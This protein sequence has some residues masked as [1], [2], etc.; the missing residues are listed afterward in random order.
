METLVFK[1]A[2]FVVQN[3]IK[4]R[5]KTCP[6]DCRNIINQLK[7]TNCDINKILFNGCKDGDLYWVEFAVRNGADVNYINTFHCLSCL[8][9][10]L[11]NSR[12]IGKY[13]VIQILEF[14]ESKGVVF[15]ENCV[16]NARYSLVF[17][18]RLIKFLAN[19]VNLHQIDLLSEAVM[20]NQLET[21]KVL[22]TLGYTLGQGSLREAIDKDYVEMVEYILS[23]GVKPTS[24]H[25]HNAVFYDYRDI[26]KLLV[27]N[28]PSIITVELIL[29][30]LNKER[31]AI[32]KVLVQH[33]NLVQTD[34]RIVQ[35]L[36]YC[37]R[38]KFLKFVVENFNFNFNLDLKNATNKVIQLLNK[39]E[40]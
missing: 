18:P 37:N 29:M 33:S 5:S 19:K 12:H 32:A 14:L 21:I 6:Q 22:I 17:Q 34:N 30:A 25:L 16:M 10:V 15:P 4:H 2:R 40:K 23:R 8:G 38:V 31:Y 11:N 13:R 27:E 7:Q 24:I 36:V 35:N 28:D 3:K 39:I 1:C 9:A 20:C 26:A